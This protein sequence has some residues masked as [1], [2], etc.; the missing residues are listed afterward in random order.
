MSNVN[1]GY[2]GIAII[3]DKK[4]RC[5]D[6]SVN[7][8]QEPLFYNHVIGLNDTIPTD[9]STKGEEVGVIQIQKKFMRPSTIT[10]QGGM[11]F[12]AAKTDSDDVNFQDIFNYAKYGNYFDINYKHFCESG[13]IFSDCRINTFDFNVTSGDTV[14]INIDVMGKDMENSDVLETYTAPEK[15]VTWDEITFVFDGD[16][17]GLNVTDS[18][19][20]FQFS[21][22]N[23]VTPI[24]TAKPNPEDP[25]VTY[26]NFLPKDLRLGMQEVTGSITIYVKQGRDFLD[27]LTESGVLTITCSTFT[28]PIYAVFNPKQIPG[29]VGPV[30]ITIPFVGVDKA[31]GE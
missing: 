24:Y 1:A 13:R 15:L 11:S 28:T 12:P 30:I 5:G 4:I 25:E 19:Q 26:K 9:S 7:Q 27:T 17:G 16:T 22:N 3:G 21:I 6:F 29:L 23:N 18:I 31:F 8:I 2:R 14:N 20:S 10:I